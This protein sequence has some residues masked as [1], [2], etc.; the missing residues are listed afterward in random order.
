LPMM[1]P[2]SGWCYK[3]SL[4]CRV[5]FNR[6]FRDNDNGKTQKGSTKLS[7]FLEPNEN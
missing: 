7:T 4:P 5:H 6:S 2:D 1:T 3:Q